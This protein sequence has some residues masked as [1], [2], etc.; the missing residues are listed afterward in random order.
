MILAIVIMTIIPLPTLLLDIFIALNL[1]FALI[2]LLIGI[3]YKQIYYFTLYPTLLLISIFFNL[4]VNLSATRLIL[5]KG[6]EFD[7]RLIKVLSS[8]IVGSEGER[9]I[10][11]LIIFIVIIAIHVIVVTKGCTRISE[12][13]CLFTLDLPQMKQMD[14]DAKFNSGTITENEANARRNRLQIEVDF[15]DSLD[16]TSK[17]LSGNEKARI[18]IITLSFIGAILI[19]TLLNGQSINDAIN[20]SVPL[21]IGNGILCVLPSLFLSIAMGIIISLCPIVWVHVQQIRKLDQNK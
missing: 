13:V 4:A 6:A 12:V 3:L 20:T 21:V 9:L 16:G 19:G 17:F 1:I 2:V 15:W 8:F 18:I 14:I 11:G 5:T 10:I 7:G